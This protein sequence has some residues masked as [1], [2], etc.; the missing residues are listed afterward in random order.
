MRKS[1]LVAGAFA[2][3]ASSALA[4]SNVIVRVMASNLTSGNNQRYETAGRDEVPKLVAGL[5][6]DGQRV[7]G[8]RLLSSTLEEVYLEAVGGE[9]S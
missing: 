6:A 1:I 2:L 5:V 4:Q 8:V 3:M 9:T 7:Y